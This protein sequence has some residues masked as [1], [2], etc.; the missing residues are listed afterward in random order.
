MQM[1][2]QALAHAL[3]TER[4][5]RRKGEEGYLARLETLGQLLS[6]EIKREK[7]ERVAQDNALITLMD[8]ICSRV[9]DAFSS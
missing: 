3:D 4:A 1:T 8:Q 6:G 9:K 2:H 7:E 5:E